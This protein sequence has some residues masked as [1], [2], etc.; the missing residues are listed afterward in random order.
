MREYLYRP[1]KYYTLTAGQNINDMALDIK[2]NEKAYLTGANMTFY[3]GT[4]T[5]NLTAA[6]HDKGLEF[7]IALIDHEPL[8]FG[9]EKGVQWTGKVRCYKN[10]IIRWLVERAVAADVIKVAAQ[11]EITRYG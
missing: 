11:M 3:S 6:L 7:A 2:D 8:F 4:G 5:G 9:S 1:V 10:D